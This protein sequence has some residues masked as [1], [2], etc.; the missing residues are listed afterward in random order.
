M[1]R[2]FLFLLCLGLGASGM[3]ASPKVTFK[4]S[5]LR[6]VSGHDMFRLLYQK[7]PH[8]KFDKIDDCSAFSTR[9]RAALGDSNPANGEL[10]YRGPSV[11]YVKWFLRCVNAGIASELEGSSA[12]AGGMTVFFGQTALAQI[13]NQPYASVVEKPKTVPWMDLPSTIQSSILSHLIDNYIGPGIV[14]DQEGLV[15]KLLVAV[16]DKQTSTYDA[17]A[18]EILLV[19]TQDEF[20]TY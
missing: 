16:S 3:A 15:K 13:A 7:F 17:L 10:V 2:P 14:A 4:D 6:Y 20:L 5:Y 8:A 11:P 9:N 18:K 19:S 1:K 12:L